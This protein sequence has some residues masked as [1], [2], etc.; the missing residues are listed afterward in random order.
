MVNQQIAIVDPAG[1][2][3][4]DPAGSFTGQPGDPLV[5][6]WVWALP[7]GISGLS[8]RYAAHPPGETCYFGMDFSTVLPRTSAIS[9]AS[10]LVFTNTFVTAPVESPAWT[11]G[12]V[13]VAGGRRVFAL[14]SGGVEGTD[15]QVRWTI[16][17]QVGNVFIRTAMVLV[18]QTS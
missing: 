14:F 8:R 4:R 15:Y 6:R 10:V 3:L 11:V 16:A 12:P 2:A 18:A 13:K 5:P 7:E 9:A 17:D 1:A